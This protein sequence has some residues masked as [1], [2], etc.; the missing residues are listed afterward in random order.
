V[1]EAL[2]MVDALTF[3]ETNGEV[4]PANWAAGKDGMKADFKG[5]AEYLSKH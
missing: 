3:F 5:V 2:R 4:C 1:D